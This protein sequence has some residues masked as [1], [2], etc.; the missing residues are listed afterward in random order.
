MAT[1]AG[2]DLLALDE[3]GPVVAVQGQVGADGERAAHGVA[4]DAARVADEEQRRTGV[5]LGPV[6]VEPA[7]VGALQERRDRGAPLAAHPR[8]PARAGG[9]DE[10][11]AGDLVGRRSCRGG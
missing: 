10:V 5:G 11:E 3:L 1:P 4:V 6:G 2:G 9:V 8:R 7:G